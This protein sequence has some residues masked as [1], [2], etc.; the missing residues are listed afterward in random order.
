MKL[1]R[2]VRRVK[3][4]LQPVG[5]REGWLKK[6]SPNAFKGQQKRYFVLREAMLY[7][8]KEQGDTEAKGVIPLRQ[9]PPHGTSCVVTPT[10]ICCDVGSA[11][12]SVTVSDTHLDINVGYRIF[13]LTAPTAEAANEWQQE[14][15]RFIPP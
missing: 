7:Y 9:V 13:N 1:Q 15:H 3:R 8:Y 10:M 5:M 2:E 4:L 6:K 14:Q 12:K 11:L